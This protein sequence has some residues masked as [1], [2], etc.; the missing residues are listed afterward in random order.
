MKL[1]ELISTI[2]RS[3]FKANQDHSKWT[4]GW[5]L[6]VY[7]VE[8]FLVARIAD[9]IMDPKNITN[10]PTYLTL[11]TRFSELY[12]NH[13]KLPPERSKQCLNERNRIDI[14]LYTGE[15]F[16]HAIEIKR[17]W[18]PACLGDLNRLCS[19]I[20]HCG[21][22]A[23]GLLKVG[24]FVLLIEAKARKSQNVHE[25]LNNS[26]ASKEQKCSDY[27]L[28]RSDINKYYFSRGTSVI[29]PEIL[30]NGWGFS[31]LCVVVK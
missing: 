18:S 20:Q 9:A 19:L 14:A 29:G 12:D 21:K 30:D 3:A 31:T 13:G 7:G 15:T 24:I 10:P 25:C 26:F 27:L 23:G 2:H 6:S 8:G 4:G 1:E 11:E 28:K 22:S 16:T 17:F 5:W